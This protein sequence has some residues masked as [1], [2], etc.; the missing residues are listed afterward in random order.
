MLQVVEAPRKGIYAWPS[1]LGKLA[2]EQNLDVRSA[3]ARNNN[4]RF[5]FLPSDSST[6]SLGASRTNPF[7]DSPSRYLVTMALEGSRP[8]YALKHGVALETRGERL[9]NRSVMRAQRVSEQR[10]GASTAWLQEEAQ[11]SCGSGNCDV[12]R[13]CADGGWDGDEGESMGDSVAC[14]GKSVSGRHVADHVVFRRIDSEHSDA[15]SFLRLPPLA[16]RIA[17]APSF[18]PRQSGEPRPHRAATWSSS[19]PHSRNETDGGDEGHGWHLLINGD[20]EAKLSP[21][22]GGCDKPFVVAADCAKSTTPTAAV[23]HLSES[24]GG[25]ATPGTATYGNSGSRRPPDTWHDKHL[26]WSPF[27]DSL[28]MPGA[29]PSLSPR[30]SPSLSPRLSLAALDSVVLG[31]E[32]WRSIERLDGRSDD[33]E[34]CGD[35]GRGAQERCGAEEGCDSGNDG[36]TP[37]DDVV[38]DLFPELHVAAHDAAHD[39]ASPPLPP[40]ATSDIVLQVPAI[41]SPPAPPS[42]RSASPSLFGSLPAASIRPSPSA[43]ARADSPPL[44]AAQ[45]PSAGRKPIGAATRLVRGAPH[46]WGTAPPLLCARAPDGHDR[47]ACALLALP[48]ASARIPPPPGAQKRRADELGKGEGARTGLVDTPHASRSSENGGATGA[49]ISRSAARGGAH[50]RGP[51]QTGGAR[52]RPGPPS[53]LLL[54]PLALPPSSPPVLTAPSPTLSALTLPSPLALPTPSTP[55][56][57]DCAPN[58]ATAPPRQPSHAHL[59]ANPSPARCPATTPSRPWRNHGA[60]ERPGGGDF[61]G[62]AVGGGAAVGP[63]AAVTGR[64]AVGIRKIVGAHTEAL[65]LRGRGKADAPV[66][67]EMTAGSLVPGSARLDTASLLERAAAYIAFLH[68][69]SL[70]A[71]AGHADMLQAR[72]TDGLGGADEGVEGS[73]SDACADAAAAAAAAGGGA[74][75]GD[76]DR[77]ASADDVECMDI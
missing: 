69:H 43:C 31:D 47:R 55:F 3:A 68:A 2:D 60:A 75:A 58:T 4:S 42:P 74:G 30:L 51:A 28:L 32:L 29:S 19:A 33:E 52:V 40:P 16:E 12:A 15:P 70:A 24:D 59:P 77:G 45:L 27:G 7:R 39:A 56:P 8:Y 48:S 37:W 71:G 13:S 64:A 72:F 1:D 10:F 23:P 61:G 62:T 46:T 49:P 38:K 11:E 63:G 73:G 22:A 26:L 20:S 54:P 53:P 50:W 6:A 65:G 17:T 36:A 5:A 34:G 21:G 9:S 44:D 41:S 76:G 18:G 25:D 67:M 35:E 14:G 57:P 66:P